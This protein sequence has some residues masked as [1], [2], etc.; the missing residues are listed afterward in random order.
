MF[1]EILEATLLVSYS[2]SNSDKTPVLSLIKNKQEERDE[3]ET[4]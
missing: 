2:H 3:M 1:L 4:R